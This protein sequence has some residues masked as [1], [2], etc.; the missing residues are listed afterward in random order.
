[1]CNEI[2]ENR[3]SVF[4]FSLPESCLKF[5]CLKPDSFGRPRSVTRFVGSTSPCCRGT[6]ARRENGTSRAYSFAAG[7]GELDGGDGAVVFEEGGDP[8]EGFDLAVFP[9]AGV[10]W[11]D[12]AAGNA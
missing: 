3:A 8:G 6:S 5:T 12:A 1:M 2:R 4:F 9:E 10:L 7:V 11:G